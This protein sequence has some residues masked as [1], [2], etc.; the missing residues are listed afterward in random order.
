MIIIIIG[1]ILVLRGNSTFTKYTDEKSISPTLKE[2]P[3]VDLKNQTINGKRVIGLPPGD[4]AQQLKKIKISNIVTSDWQPNLER[5]IKAQGGNAVKS[6]A[7]R[8]LDSFIWNQD[9]LSLNVE[10]VIVTVK[11]HKNQETS[12]K[13]LVDAQNGKI[14]KNWDQPIF[15]PLQ[16]GNNFKININPR[17]H[18][19]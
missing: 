4:T 3:I 18:D 2:Q 14:L 5:T 11:N 8:S 16:P 10:S 7:I 19:E 15:D 9:G 1:I 6:I 13:A 17:Y 12:F